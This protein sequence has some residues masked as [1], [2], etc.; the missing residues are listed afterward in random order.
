MRGKTE[1]DKRVDFYAMISA[2]R[3]KR[4]PSFMSSIVH[5]VKGIEI[6]AMNLQVPGEI[7][8]YRIVLSTSSK[9]I[10]SETARF[11]DWVAEIE[12][13]LQEGAQ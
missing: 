7:K 2:F 10:P 13:E 11:L 12:R 4:R 8:E 9:T 6:I 1:M 3:N 5:N